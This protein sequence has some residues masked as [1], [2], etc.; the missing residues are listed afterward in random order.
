MNISTIR[1]FL[2]VQL[3]NLIKGIKKISEFHY[4]HVSILIADFVC[5]STKIYKYQIVI[6]V[7]ETN[8]YTFV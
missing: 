3:T 7:F 2:S 6:I 8:F 4:K 5:I 1:R